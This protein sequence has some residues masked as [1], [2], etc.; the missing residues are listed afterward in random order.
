MT[1]IVWYYTGEYVFINLSKSI[2]RITPRANPNVNQ[3]LWETMTGQRRFLNY[4]D[5][6]RWCGML[7]VV[8]AV[9]MWELSVP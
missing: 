8:K 9:G 6:P 4:D 1:D 5:A 3:G 2:D 7:M